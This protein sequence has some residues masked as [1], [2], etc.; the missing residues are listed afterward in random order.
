MWLIIRIMYYNAKVRALK[1]IRNFLHEAEEAKVPESTPEPTPAPEQ[2]G[3]DTPAETNNKADSGTSSDAGGFGSGDSAESQETDNAPEASG[4]G[5][6]P[7]GDSSGDPAGGSGSDAEPPKEE[8][9]ETEKKEKEE[10]PKDLIFNEFK[11]LVD[12]DVDEYEL[13]KYLKA[14]II[15]TQP[16]D[17]QGFISK[18]MKDKEIPKQRNVMLAFQKLQQ[19]IAT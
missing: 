16:K 9:S 2:A 19:F 11:G 4:E 17:F 12:A 8:S 13:L 14:K 3:T 6:S 7:A 1:L 15:E 18:L 10:S 5:A